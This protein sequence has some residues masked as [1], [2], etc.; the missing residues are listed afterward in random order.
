MPRNGCGPSSTPG[1]SR[2]ASSTSGASKMSAQLNLFH[3]PSVTSSP[4]SAS[5][6]TRC[7]SP[8]GQTTN[9]S[10]PAHARA[11]LSARQ[12]K[13]KGLLTSGT[14]GRPS[15]TS[16]RSAA[17]A[18]SL[19]NRLRART[20][21]SGSTLYSLTWKARAT[22]AQR[23]ISA[24]RAS[25]HRTSASASTGWPTPNC[26]RNHD[27]DLS[28]GGLY[29][30]KTQ[31]DLPE[32]AWLADWT[33]TP[34]IPGCFKDK[35]LLPLAGWATPTV[36]D[37][38]GT[39]YN[40]YSEAGKG[41]NR[42]AALQ[43]QAQLANGPARRTATGEML[44]GSSAG[45]ESGGQLNPAHSRWLMGLPAAW[46]D[47]APTVMRSSRKSRKLSSNPISHDDLLS[48]ILS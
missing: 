28:A 20:A 1:I 7:A 30:T 22:P 5:G 24:L 11:S 25:A 27:S 46:D 16:S 13:A 21:C 2:P 48:Q 31:T 38:K 41:E 36:H 37:T 29:A 40:R 3:L 42:S 12:A 15:S 33:Q 34:V 32:V 44:T 18:L 35:T 19:A 26:P 43:D 39:D 6:P 4:A 10:G 45:M 14:Y 8:D 47:C 9:L 17:L 23:S